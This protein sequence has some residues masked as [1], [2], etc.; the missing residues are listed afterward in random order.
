MGIRNGVYVCKSTEK[1]LYE[2]I[3]PCIRSFFEQIGI[4]RVGLVYG[5]RVIL[6][7]GQS[8]MY[9]YD[10]WSQDHFNTITA[11][12]E[13]VETFKYDL[14]ELTGIDDVY[15]GKVK[16]GN[17]WISISARAYGYRRV[18]LMVYI[19]KKVDLLMIEGFEAGFITI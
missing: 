11:D 17:K 15:H 6:M 18:T 4:N 8:Q 13:E 14:I 10:S 19:A 7:F 16:I 2:A 9:S 3:L 1:D 5:D 12:A